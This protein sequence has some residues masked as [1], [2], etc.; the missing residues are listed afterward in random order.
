MTQRITCLM[1]IL[2]SV[3]QNTSSHFGVREWEIKIQSIKY[4]ATMK[5]FTKIK[6]LLGMTGLKYKHQR[7]P[8]S[9]DS[10]LAFCYGQS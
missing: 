2:S 6:S 8:A 5:C 1:L 7:Y 9:W 10:S 3:C 4:M